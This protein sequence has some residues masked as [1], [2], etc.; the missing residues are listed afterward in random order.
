MTANGAPMTPDVA[1]D[2][3]GLFMLADIDPNRDTIASAV[4][5]I[6]GHGSTYH[7]VFLKD[8]GMFCFCSDAGMSRRLH[9]AVRKIDAESTG[10]P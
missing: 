10:R 5:K 6:R 9:A 8:G 2:L 7:L 4:T 1:Q 3:L